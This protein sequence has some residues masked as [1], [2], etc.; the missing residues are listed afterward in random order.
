MNPDPKPCKYHAYLDECVSLHLP[1]MVH[2]WHRQYSAY[3]KPASNYMMQR[4]YSKN[5]IKLHM[6][7]MCTKECAQQHRCRQRTFAAGTVSCTAYLIKAAKIVIQRRM[8]AQ[9]RPLPSRLGGT[10]DHLLPTLQFIGTTKM[11]LSYIHG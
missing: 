2:Q 4:C 6:R 5:V 10:L 1:T 7:I 8:A 11:I 9:C 3:A